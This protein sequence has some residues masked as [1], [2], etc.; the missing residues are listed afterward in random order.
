MKTDVE[1]RRELQ[2]RL[3]AAQLELEKSEA[4]NQ[5]LKRLVASLR[6]VLASMNRNGKH[7]VQQPLT[8]PASAASTVSVDRGTLA[9]MS[10]RQAAV[11][12][13]SK[14]PMNSR[15]LYAVFERGGRK[16]GGKDPLGTLRATLRSYK[17]VFKRDQD[18]RWMVIDGTAKPSD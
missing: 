4:E 3:D 6:G 16:I 1:L 14:Q 17:K 10:M 13:L 11:H 5:R 12:V 15:D 9:D 7:P 2:A 18:G 8:L